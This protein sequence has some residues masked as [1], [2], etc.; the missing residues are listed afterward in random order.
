MAKIHKTIKDIQSRVEEMEEEFNT[1]RQGCANAEEQKSDLSDQLESLYKP[2]QK[3]VHKFNTLNK[4]KLKVQRSAA[5]LE[6]PK[7]KKKQQLLVSIYN[8]PDSHKDQIVSMIL[9]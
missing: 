8:E 1:E 2:E 3:Q 4:D 5:I 9:K 6:K 7:L